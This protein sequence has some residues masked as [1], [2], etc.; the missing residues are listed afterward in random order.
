MRQNHLALEAHSCG[1]GAVSNTTLAM[2]HEAAFAHKRALQITRMR[3]CSHSDNNQ[4]QLPADASLIR[5]A[6]S[7]AMRQPAGVLLLR[8][9]RRAR[10]SAQMLM[11][12]LVLLLLLFGRVYRYEREA[13]KQH[14]G[15]AS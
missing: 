1:G 11:I 8:A 6:S 3:A 12:A 7:D 14:D 10:A 13:N 9:Q 2:S 15:T 4:P 5:L